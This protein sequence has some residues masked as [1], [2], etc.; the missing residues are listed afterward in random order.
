[1]AGLPELNKQLLKLYQMRMS[2]NLMCVEFLRMTLSLLALIYSS[3][4]YRQQSSH[5]MAEP[6]LRR[7]I[8]DKLLATGMG[9][10]FQKIS[11]WPQCICLQKPL[12]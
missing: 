9:S 3:F 2:I 7:F 5:R 8:L 6:L 1:M 4:R 12:R 10:P 11:V